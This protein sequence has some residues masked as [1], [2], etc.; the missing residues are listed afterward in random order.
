VSH[1]GKPKTFNTEEQS[2]QRN[3]KDW[4]IR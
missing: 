3:E 2:K 1:N 4:V